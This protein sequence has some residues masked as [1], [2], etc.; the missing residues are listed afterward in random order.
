MTAHLRE[1][2]EQCHTHLQLHHL[3]LKRACH[4]PL[5]QPLEAVHLGLGL[6][7]AAPVVAAPLLP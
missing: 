3:A 7:Q 1:V 2:V 5:A 4:H 6:D